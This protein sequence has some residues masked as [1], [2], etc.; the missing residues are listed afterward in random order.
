MKKVLVWDTFPLQNTGGPM[1]YLYNLHEYL[2]Q[3][4]TDQIT[5]LSDAMIEK[6]GDAEWLHP[7]YSPN[8]SQN[9]LAQ[10]WYQLRKAYCMCLKPFWQVE[11]QVPTEINI[12]QYDYVHIH[13]ITHVSQ[14]RKLFPHYKGNV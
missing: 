2:K 11:Y 10:I 3:H 1:G 6:F 9:R 4:P 7:V 5:F 8:N 14:F 12:D 13:I